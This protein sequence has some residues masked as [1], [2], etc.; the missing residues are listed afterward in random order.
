[1][2]IATHSDQALGLLERPSEAECAT[3][4]AIRYQSNRAVLHTDAS[5]LPTREA[6]WAA[7][8]YERTA[9]VGPDGAQ[10]CLHY[11]LNRLQPLPWQQPVI[12]SLNPV[13]P[14]DPQTVLGEYDYAHPVF[15]LN[16]VAAQGRMSALQGQNS[17][18]YCGAWMGYGFHEDGLKAGLAAAAQLLADVGRA[19]TGVR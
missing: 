14:I 4:G 5:V 1:V 7:W 13:R 6:A 16:A 19:T 18:Y 15:D 9:A 2:I 11:L 8:N 3:L 17:R 12:V 10:V